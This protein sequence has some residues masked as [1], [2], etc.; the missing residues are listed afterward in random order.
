MI[1]SFFIKP[2]RKDKGA[3]LLTTLLVMS[4]MAT[5]A[6]SLFDSVRLAVK[7]SA[8][9][10]AYVQADWYMRGVGDVAQD[11][12]NTQLTTLKA[13]QF[14]T[15]LQRPEPIVFPIDG[16]AITMMLR[17]GDQCFAL[18]AL[19]QS[20]GRIQFRQLLETLGWNTLDAATLTSQAA[21]WIDADQQALPNGGEDY[22]YLGNSLSHRTANTVF[23]SVSELR[24]LPGLDEAGF[25]TLRPFL[26]AREADAVNAVNINTL[27]PSHAP[28]LASVL[29]GKDT[30]SIAKRL[31]TERPSEG[32][33]NLDQIMAAPALLDVD[34]QNMAF[35]ILTL[36]PNHIWVEVDVEIGGIRRFGNLEYDI[37]TG[38][39]ERTFRRI[40]LDARRPTLIDDPS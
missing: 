3:V 12:L 29:G 11:N 21:D 26:C 39:A 27:L 23:T 2:D 33:N 15:I 30:L 1:G 17:D 5:V 7:R 6:V 31:I 16:G 25:Q 22:L 36:V 4:L 10:Q 18:S 38:H 19:T 35:D 20:P 28:L 9:V 14:N 34:T 24:V 37:S 40:G 32:Y 13:A 8:N